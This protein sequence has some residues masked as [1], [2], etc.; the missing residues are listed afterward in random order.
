MNINFTGRDIE[1]TE[2]IKSY[3]TSKLSKLEK[4]LGE[5]FDASITFKIEGNE[6]I[7]EFRVTSRKKYL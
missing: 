6:Q 2:A 5:D 1:P 4:Y 3:A 7:A